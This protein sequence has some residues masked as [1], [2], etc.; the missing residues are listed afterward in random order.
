MRNLNDNKIKLA[1]QKEGRL[2]DET[3][4]FLRNS[5]LAFEDY[6]QRLFSSCR[7]FPMD[8]LF[9]R[10][11]D[12]SGYVSNGVVDLGIIGQNILNETR[13]EVKKLL[14]LRFGFCL[15][16]IAVPKESNI[17]S[18]KDL[19][20]KIVATTYPESTRSFLEKNNI[21]ARVIKISGSVE[22]APALGIA[23]VIADL[24]STGSTL[25]LNDL[26]VLTKI[27]DSEAVLI[28]N[29]N[30]SISEKKQLLLNNLLIRFK[31]VLS[32][33]NYKY[34]FLNA[35]KKVLPRLIK[36]LPGLKYPTVSKLANEDWVSIQAV[37]KEDI[38]WETVER[39]K[40]VGA[41]GII[42]LPI[43]KAIL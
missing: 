22:L 28:A 3:L 41:S 21:K 25:A 11:D 40:R 39:L 42:M 8:L 6:K 16:T 43:E 34:I 26:R 4:D 24:S 33:K 31:G 35:P 27:Y 12:I 5:G 29:R 1:I 10:D 36:I 18:L 2:T 7:N 14:N 32:A 38:F 13:S 15:L 17:R 23:E 19:N 9:V 37:V 30:I 20:G